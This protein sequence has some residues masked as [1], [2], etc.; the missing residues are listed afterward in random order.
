M[1][2]DLACNLG[3][4]RLWHGVN[5]D[6][7]ATKN[8]AKDLQEFLPTLRE[9]I[10]RYELI[11]SRELVNFDRETYLELVAQ[12]IQEAKNW[13]LENN[14]SQE[15]V[16]I[17]GDH[18]VSFVSLLAILERYKQ[19]KI[20][21]LIFDSHDDFNLAGLSET[22]NF[23]GMWVRP[24]FTQFDQ[25][26][27]NSLVPEKLPLSN[28]MYVGNL[29][30]ELPVKKFFQE[31]QIMV[32]K[33]EDFQKDFWSSKVL[34]DDFVKKFDHIHVSFD[35]DVVQGEAEAE[36]AS[37]GNWAVNLPYGGGMPI[38]L[39]KKIWQNID[40]PMDYSLDLVEY[41]S[42]RKNQKKVTADLV[43]TILLQKLR[44]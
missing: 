35:L 38:S 32:L 31:N 5:C 34:I 39:I 30:M 17:G 15:Q 19:K 27:I 11:D 20:G 28:L 3:I 24:F 23:H 25:K 7:T 14:Q 9:R 40:L 2:F 10:R 8:G 36:C 13:L 12:E 1:W 26:K 37:S 22:G 18:M 29:D 43:K 21:L 6:L 33:Q 41:N 44:H 42:A 4:R 16:V